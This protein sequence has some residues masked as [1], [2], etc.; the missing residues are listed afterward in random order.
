M[1]DYLYDPAK[2]GVQYPVVP[3]GTTFKDPV[4][5][6]KVSDI[7]L[8]ESKVDRQALRDHVQDCLKSGKTGWKLVVDGIEYDFEMRGLDEGPTFRLVED[9]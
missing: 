3:G 2:P 4:T 5:K 8:D 7:V 6:E 9:E 1:S